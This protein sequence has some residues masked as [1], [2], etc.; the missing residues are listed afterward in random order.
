MSYT[1]HISSSTVDS[2]TLRSIVSGIIAQNTEERDARQKMYRD[3]VDDYAMV[4]FCDTGR[5]LDVSKM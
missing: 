5:R 3:G 1:Q 4:G 2:T